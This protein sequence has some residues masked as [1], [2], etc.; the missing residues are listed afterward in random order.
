[1][2]S[3]GIESARGSGELEEM[4]VT[5]GLVKPQTYMNRSGESV[6]PLARFYKIPPERILII[7]DDICIYDN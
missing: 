7:Y 1:M 5:V 3:G 2:R 4:T 6:G